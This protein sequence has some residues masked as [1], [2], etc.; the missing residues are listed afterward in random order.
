MDGLSKML[1]A[2]EAALAQ[3]AHKVDTEEAQLAQVQEILGTVARQRDCPPAKPQTPRTRKIEV[4]PL[5][6]GEYEAVPKYLKGRL[7]LDRIASW[8]DAFQRVVSEKYGLMQCNPARLSGEQ[9]T[10]WF[11]WRDED[12]DECKG[13]AF[14]TEADLRARG[15]KL[16][17]AVLAILRHCGRIREVRSAGIVRFVLC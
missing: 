15:V 12:V 2:I 1:D 7:T 8:A 11:E 4:A 16:D 14:V 10:R 9:R 3:L 13:R 6:A 17:K 5:S